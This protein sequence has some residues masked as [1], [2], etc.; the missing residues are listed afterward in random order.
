[1]IIGHDVDGDWGLVKRE[2]TARELPM[3]REYDFTDSVRNPYAKRFRKQVTVRLGADV[4]VHN[5]PARR[6][7]RSQRQTASVNG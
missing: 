4:R 3:K 7:V 2:C 1:M 5:G 6:N